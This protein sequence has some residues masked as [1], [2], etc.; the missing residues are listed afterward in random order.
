MFF[1]NKSIRVAHFKNVGQCLV[2]IDVSKAIVYNDDGNNRRVVQT[3]VPG[4]YR[5]HLGDAQIELPNED[6]VILKEPG[7]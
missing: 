1:N 2:G 3:H 4:K 7:L 5:M 6:V